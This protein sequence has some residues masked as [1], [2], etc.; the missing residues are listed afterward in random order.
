MS[1]QMTTE[2]L[3]RRLVG[4]DTVSIAGKGG[5]RVTQSTRLIADFVSELLEAGGFKIWQLPYTTDGVEKVNLVAFKGGEE[6]LL[7]FS[8]HMDVVPVGEWKIA[9]DPFN[10]TRIGD[11]F[12]GRGSADMKLFDAIAVLAGCAIPASSL[13]RPFA[14]YLTSDEEI[15]CLGVKQLLKRASGKSDLQ[16]EF[17][18]HALRQR[19]VP[20]PKYVV[21]GE[22]TELVPMHMHKG[23]IFFR[24]YIKITA[25][26]AGHSSNPDSGKSVL[27]TGLPQVLI[28]LTELEAAL[29]EIRDERFAIAFPT[30]NPGV[31]SMDSGAAKNVL[32]TGCCIDLEARFLPGQEPEDLLQA[33]QETVRRSVYRLKGIRAHVKY[34][35]SPT[36]PMET[37][38]DSLVVT[39]ATKLYNKEP[40]TVAYNT[41][42]GTFNRYGA[43]SVIFGPASIDQAHKSDEFAH[44]KWFKPEIVDMYTEFIRQFCC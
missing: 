9:S 17:K 39:V 38:V 32:A 8:G 20:I 6:P 1:A 42:G 11:K 18:V 29:R 15:G 40:S 7:A 26:E 22:P 4:F 41:E 44:A 28:A 35:R 37:P 43:E 27:K 5:E 30:I 33:I 2:E 13:K 31:V 36:P 34:F 14:V 3:T 19:E 10:L 16:S 21:I 24:I 12:Y 23:Y 25:G